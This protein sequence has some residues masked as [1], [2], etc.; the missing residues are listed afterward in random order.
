MPSTWNKVASGQIVEQR[1]PRTGRLS[2]GSSVS[3]Y[4]KLPTETLISEGW[5]PVVEDKPEYDPETELLQ[6]ES[7]NILS[8]QVLYT[9]TAVAKPEP[10]PVPPRIDGI[11]L[12]ADKTQITAD[13]VDAVTVTAVFE[14]HD[15][16]T[17]PCYITV[18]GPPAEQAEIVDGEVVREFVSEEAGHFR[19][20]VFA[21]QAQKTIFIEAVS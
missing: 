5:L 14:G 4:H 1:L 13:G 18:N 15:V 6:V 20:D 16:D 21:G 7:V 8:D 2:D 19:V 9:Y 12:T 3:N 17:I 10:E 11:T